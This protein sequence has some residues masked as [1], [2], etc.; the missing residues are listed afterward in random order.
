MSTSST[1]EVRVSCSVRWTSKSDGREADPPVAGRGPSRRRVLL[2]AERV[3]QRPAQVEVERVAELVRLGRLLALPSPTRRGR[4]DDRRT[5]RAG[6]ARTGRRGPSGR[7]AGCR[8]G[9]APAARRRGS[10]S[11]PPRAAGRG[12]R[13]RRVR[14]R[15]SSPSRS[16]TSSRS[17]AARSPG[18]STSDR[19]SSSAVH[20]L[21]P[22]RSGPARLRARAAR[23]RRTGPDRRGRRAAAGRGSRPAGRGRPASRSSRSSASI[24]DWSSARCS[25]LIERSSDCIAA[26]RWASWSMMSSNVWAPGKNRPCLARNSRR[27]RVAAADPLADQ[28]VEVADHLAVGG[29]VLRASSTG[30]P[31]TCPTRTGRAPGPGAS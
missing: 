15:A 17:I 5:R 22:A 29:Q 26:I 25:G 30:S 20:R 21:E 19:A 31:R 27:V 11:R 2:A 10:G 23:R 13:A 9:S 4:S 7:S 1:V 12:R 14:A 18:D 28:L 6:A 24:I 16:R 3:E 8:A